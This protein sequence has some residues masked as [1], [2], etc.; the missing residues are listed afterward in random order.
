MPWQLKSESDI[1]QVFVEVDEDGVETGAH[2]IEW[3][4]ERPP[5]WGTHDPTGT[6]TVISAPAPRRRRG[7]A[8]A[9]F[10]GRAAA[11]GAIAYGLVELTKLVR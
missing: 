2:R 4:D 6:P 9:S 11:A 1:E 10:A 7:R 5:T 8:A 3:R